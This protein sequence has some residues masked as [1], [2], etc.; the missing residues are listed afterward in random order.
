MPD[1]RTEVPLLRSRL[2]EIT[3]VVSQPRQD[4]PRTSRFGVGSQSL[5]IGSNKISSCF[6]SAARSVPRVLWPG[7]R[8]NSLGGFTNLT[9][10]AS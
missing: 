4:V 10:R 1:G 2:F 5:T 9:R 3:V 8:G 6:S 7:S